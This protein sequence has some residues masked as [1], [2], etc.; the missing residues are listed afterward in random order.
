MRTPYT[1]LV[2]GANR[3]IGLEMVK[4]SLADGW[5][6]IACCR[7]PKQAK[8]LRA[9]QQDKL[10]LMELD[11]S[12]MRSIAR[13]GKELQNES[14]DVLMNNAGVIGPV[15]DAL[16][17]IPAA[18]WLETFQ[19]NSIAPY[20][21]AEALFR[22]IANSRLK[23]IANLSSIYGSIEKNEDLCNFVAYR[24]SKSALNA[25][26]KCLANGMKGEGVIAVSVHPGSVLTDMNPTGTISPSE[27]VAGLRNLFALLKQSDNGAFFS[28]DQTRL[29]W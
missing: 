14:I 23:I 3:G 13:L 21:L 9:L 24:A 16:A 2:T 4:Q 18:E 29:P 1:I 17:P 8:E 11:V 7:R 19:V 25:A 27:S 22:P 12:Q 20:A 10:L 5:R 15:N 6:V 26:T 28:Y